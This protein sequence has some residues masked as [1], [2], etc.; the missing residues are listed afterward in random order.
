MGGIDR[1]F[2]KQTKF[3]PSILI[4]SSSVLELVVR[5]VKEFPHLWVVLSYYAL[6]ESRR[7]YFVVNCFFF[8]ETN[9]ILLTWR[10]IF[11]PKSYCLILCDESRL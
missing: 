2:Q 10:V 9:V 1:I 4:S 3:Q 6:L 11:N 5:S 7:S 8:V